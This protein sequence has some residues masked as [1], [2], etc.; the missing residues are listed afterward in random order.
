LLLDFEQSQYP[1]IIKSICQKRISLGKEQGRIPPNASEDIEYYL[2]S[3]SIEYELDK[4]ASSGKKP[5]HIAKLEKLIKDRA[6]EE[7]CTEEEVNEYCRVL[8]SEAAIINSRIH[9]ALLCKKTHYTPTLKELYTSY[10][11]QNN[12][13]NEWFHN[14]KNGAIFLL[15]KEVKRDKLY[16][17][18]DVFSSLSSNIVRYFLELCEQSFKIAFLNDWKWNSS[19]TPEIQTEA[20]KYVSEYKITDIIGYEPFGKELRIFVQYLGQ[21]LYKLHTD[22]NSTLGEPEPNHFFTKDLSMPDNVKRIIASAIMWNVIQEGETT[23]RKQ[24]KLS[25]ETVDYYLNKIYVPFFGISYR[26]QRKIMIS[27]DILQELLSGNENTA[28]DGFNKFFKKREKTRNIKG[29]L[30][31]GDFYLEETDD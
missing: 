20:A 1:N 18:F 23:K 2:S 26:N 10:K 25:P 29:Q 11:T 21:I 8:C 13:Y 24:S 9:Y 30:S 12:K 15:C 28:L 27:V 3:Y 6:I 7:L 17:G 16:Y 4:I 22:E 19:I 5:P 31:L 14:R